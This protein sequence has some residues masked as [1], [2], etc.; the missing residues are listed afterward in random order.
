M[1]SHFFIL[2]TC[3]ETEI[4]SILIDNVMIMF[5]GGVSPARYVT[6]KIEDKKSKMIK[7]EHVG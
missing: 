6:R 5:G 7:C 1:A 4:S 2:D 3:G